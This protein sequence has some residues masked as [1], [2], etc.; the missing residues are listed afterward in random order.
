MAKEEKTRVEEQEREFIVPQRPSQHLPPRDQ[1]A[2]HAILTLK[3]FMV[4]HMKGDLEDI[5]IDPRLNE[6]LWQRSTAHIPSKVRVKGIR[7]EVGLVEGDL[8]EDE[9]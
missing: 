6:F 1:R 8:A 3:R 5:W 4:R 9:A 2:S 7:F